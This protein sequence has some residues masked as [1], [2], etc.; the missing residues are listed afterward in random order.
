MEDVRPLD[1]HINHK[2]GGK[3]GFVIILMQYMCQLKNFLN[4]GYYKQKSVSSDRG[5][6]LMPFF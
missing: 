4:S 1:Q 3:E 2:I 6:F 5:L